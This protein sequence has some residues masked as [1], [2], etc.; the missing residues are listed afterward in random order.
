MRLGSVEDTLDIYRSAGKEKLL[1]SQFKIIWVSPGVHRHLCGIFTFIVGTVTISNAWLLWMALIFPVL[2]LIPTSVARTLITRI[3][4]VDELG[5][6]F[7][8]ISF[9]GGLTPMIMS[10][11]GTSIF[12]YAVANQVNVGIV[13]FCASSLHFTGFTLSIFTDVLWRKNKKLVD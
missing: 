1:T 7:G 8:L 5:S 9:I 4:D 6:V 10:T 12:N 2:F 13:Y 3:V 11:V